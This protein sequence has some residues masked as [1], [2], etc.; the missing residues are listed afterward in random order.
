MT[1]LQMR[2]FQSAYEKQSISRTSEALNVSQP[3]VSK[4][5]QSLEWELGISLF[6]RVR[7]RI[8]P[9]DA[10][11]LLYNESKKITLL[12]DQLLSDMQQFQTKSNLLNVGVGSMSN[13]ALSRAIQDFSLKNQNISVHLTEMS[14]QRNL[15]MLGAGKID[16]YVDGD[17][18]GDFLAYSSYEH[19]VLAQTRLVFCAGSRSEFA[20]LPT[21]TPAQI[22]QYPL[23]VLDSD[24]TKDTLPSRIFSS[25]GLKANVVL[26]TNQMSVIDSL[27][28]NNLAGVIL[29]ESIVPKK[30]Y[31]CKIPLI[32]ETKVYIRLVWNKKNLSKSAAS[33]LHHIKQSTSC[34][35]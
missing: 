22:G 10:G 25:V 31:F 2:Y 8:I 13:L 26:Q 5:I 12:Y 1:L 33:F 32:P 23:I 35:D 15:S 28:K 17:T 9:T 18:S 30:K 3:T 19:L 6:S 24:V 4:S 34:E 21:I 11:H 27:I 29:F 14:H 20:G 16:F 7:N